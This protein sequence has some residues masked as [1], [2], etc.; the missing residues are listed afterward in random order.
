M[1]LSPRSLATLAALVGGLGL[2]SFQTGCA[3]TNTRE[4]TGEYVDD[5]TIT[6]KVKAAFVKDPVVKA[7]DVKVQTFKGVVQLSGF[8]DNSDQ[9]S[10]A[11]QVARG[12]PNVA[13]VQND[14]VV[15]AR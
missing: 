14:I 4:S 15:K 12:V 8:V 2:V 1:K 9:K 7:T 11:E 3:G 10:Q 13:K 5:A 6:A